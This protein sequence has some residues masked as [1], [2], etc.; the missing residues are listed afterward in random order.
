M[1]LGQAMLWGFVA[2]VVMSVILS[3]SR[4]LGFTR[5]D[6]SFMLGTVF[7]AR[8]NHAKWYGFLFHLFNGWVF[9]FIYIAAF[10]STGWKNVWFGSFIGLV[11]VLFVLIV[12]M[13][14]LPSIHPRMATEQHG[15][16]PTRLLE[17]P[18][19]MALNYGRRTPIASIIAHLVF[20]GILGFFY[21]Y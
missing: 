17:P 20:G 7:T 19:F 5:M 21:T 9:S 16:N 1:N 14:I 15:P 4:S 3:G 13:A 10:H 6:I 8:R 18:G 11:H 2:S 12:G